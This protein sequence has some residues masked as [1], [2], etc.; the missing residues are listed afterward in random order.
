[1]EKAHKLIKYKYPEYIN[2]FYTS[3]MMRKSDFLKR[4]IG[5]N[6]Y[7][8]M[9]TDGKQSHVKMLNIIFK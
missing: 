3:I 9:Y 1:M 6:I 2:N 5:L 8:R 4:G 7:Q